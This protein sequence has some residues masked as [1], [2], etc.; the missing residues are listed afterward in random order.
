MSGLQQGVQLGQQ[1]MLSPQMRES[2]AILQA[3]ALELQHMVR[4]EIET[5]PVLEEEAPEDETP[6]EEQEED[7]ADDE[8][9]ELSRLEEDWGAF[10]GE[11]A[12]NGDPEA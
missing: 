11:G 10:S 9:D 4:Q 7:G 12:Q 2:L 5:N 3:T 8:P 6:A 1:Q